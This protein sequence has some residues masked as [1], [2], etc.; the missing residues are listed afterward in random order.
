MK[1]KIELVIPLEYWAG[2]S[3]WR[4]DHVGPDTVAITNIRGKQWILMICGS[5]RHRLSY[6]WVI[7]LLMRA[8]G[9]T[10]VAAAVIAYVMMAF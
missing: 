5:R 7:L 9:M 6:G 1:R 3:D 10:M 8:T 4:L 2:K